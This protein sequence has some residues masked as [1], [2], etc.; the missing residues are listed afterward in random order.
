MS[1]QDRDYAREENPYRRMGGPG[2]DFGGLR[3]TLDNPMT[4]SV[5]LGRVAGIAVRVHVILLAYIVIRLLHSALSSS[6]S[7]FSFE[8]AVLWLA[9]LFLTILLH[10]FG[11]CIACRAVGGEANE[12]LMWPLGGLAYCRPPNHWRAHFVTAAGGPMVNVAILA[13]LAPILGGAT[14]IWWGVAI[15]NPFRF[16]LVPVGTSWLLMCLYTA[17]WINA[18]V[19]LFNMLPIFPFDGGRLTQAILWSRLGYSRSMRIAVWTGYVGASALA[20]W[21]LTTQSSTLVALA[22]FG[23]LT[24]WVTSRQVAFTDEFMG[25]DGEGYAPGEAGKARRPWQSWRQRRAQRH[26]ERAARRDRDEAG[27]V[28]RVLDKIANEGMQ[29]LS[30]AEKRLLRR[31]T[32]R[33]KDSG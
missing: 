25:F 26:A 8:I 24:C 2:G 16:N 17:S 22:I 18:I 6:G 21:G 20:L 28:D 7:A 15:P 33:K 23:G 9:C 31:A 10:E 11:H 1:W 30:A 32:R 27:R 4:W 5:P 12:I 3:P 13:V 29:G 14:G 19:V